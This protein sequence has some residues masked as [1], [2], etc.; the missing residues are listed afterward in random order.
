VF[1]SFNF[2]ASKAGWFRSHTRFE[3]FVLCPDGAVSQQITCPY[4][5]W[6]SPIGPQL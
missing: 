5:E 6:S 2:L 3:R 4:K 1:H